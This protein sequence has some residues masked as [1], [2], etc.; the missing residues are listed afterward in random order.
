VLL[1]ATGSEVQI[2]LEAQE[3]LAAKGVAARV[4][5]MPS[6]EIFAA[7]DAAYRES[8]LPKAI[9]ARVSIEA[10]V[11]LGWERHLGL[12]GKAIGLDRY[13]ASAPF[14]AIYQNLGITAE[15]M[16]DAAL[17]LLG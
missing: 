1:L 8:V 15:A 6:W 9:T 13:G 16:V 10:G 5:S 17:S 11:T 2:A 12:E 14:K 4:V 7:Q 3:K